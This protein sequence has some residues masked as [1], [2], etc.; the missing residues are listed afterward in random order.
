MVL[1][2]LDLR[3]SRGFDIHSLQEFEQAIFESFPQSYKTF[4]ATTN[5]GFVKGS[6]S[7]FNKN[8][9]WDHEGRRNT[10]Q[11]SSVEEFFQF[12]NTSEPDPPRE[13]PRSVLHELFFRH[14]DEQFLPKRVFVIGRCRQ[15]SLIAISLNKDDF[16]QVL[17]WEWY[18]RYPWYQ[19]FFDERVAAAKAKFDNIE[20]IFKDPSHPQ[21]ESAYNS[22]NYATLVKVADTFEDF[23][24][25]L[26]VD[27]DE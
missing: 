5:G 14:I 22:L 6:Q 15:N 1:S 11:Q 19:M 12:V 25:S 10:N 27:S 17:Y 18:W 9:V 20:Q 23:L 7:L 2:D 26:T 8:I 4:I 21:F 13:Q 24:A 16:G 3:G